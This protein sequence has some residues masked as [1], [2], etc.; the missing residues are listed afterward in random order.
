MRC[1]LRKTGV[2]EDG[3]LN[4]NSGDSFTM[5]YSLKFVGINSI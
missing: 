1:E 5:R 4:L 3:M 2:R